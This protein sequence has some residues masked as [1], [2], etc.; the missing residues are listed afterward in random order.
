MN[1]ISLS[2]DNTRQ[3]QRLL[4]RESV[5][6]ALDAV[7]ESTRAWAIRHSDTLAVTTSGELK[8]ALASSWTV[9]L[10]QVLRSAALPAVTGSAAAAAIARTRM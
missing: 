9:S 4:V 8:S 3:R 10:T 5:T 1:S 7:A 2:A 6:R